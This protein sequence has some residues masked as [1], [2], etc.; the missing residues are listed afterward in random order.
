VSWNRISGPSHHS[1]APHGSLAKRLHAQIL[2]TLHY[3]YTR[4][5]AT[6]SSARKRDAACLGQRD[7]GWSGGG[8]CTGRHKNAGTHRRTRL[9][10][11]HDPTRRVVAL[12][13]ASRITTSTPD[14]NTHRSYY[15]TI[16]YKAAMSGWHDRRW[17]PPCQ[18]VCVCERCPRAK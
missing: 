14:S 13:C 17:H 8:A 7:R 4:K 5:D 6:P 15:T 11:F 9:S 1:L 16:V 2:K 18:D 12:A 10:R 3:H